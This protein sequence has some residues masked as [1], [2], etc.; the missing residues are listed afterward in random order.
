MK[1]L[2]A[3][4][5]TLFIPLTGRIYATKN[6]PNL[7]VDNAAIEIGNKI[8][9][10]YLNVESANEYMYLASAS[11]NL[12]VD[13]LVKSFLKNNPGG[14][15]C[16][17]GAGLDTT[18]QR[19]KQ[20]GIKW[21][22]LDLANVI[23]ARREYIPEETNYKYIEASIFDD[24]WYQTL[25]KSKPKK[26]LFIANGLFHYFTQEQI[27]S[28]IK[29]FTENISNFELIFDTVSKNGL[30]RTNSYIK[31]MGREASCFFYI[32][33][34]QRFIKKI[35]PSIKVLPTKG[36]YVN[37]LDRIGKQ[38]KFKTKVFMKYTNIFKTV[39]LFH[40]SYSKE[41]NI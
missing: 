2:S 21:F 17:L 6:F 37:A 13:L 28:L 8:D 7:L 12:N 38:I 10:K 5:D 1:K 23:D 27:V 3:V 30:K 15:V 35:D 29:K 32:N 36:F 20:K 25:N 4:S 40:L 16:N 9:K 39:K 18:Y 11:R 31:K 41:G 34:I 22:E 24:D 33:N 19:I 26:V 14:V